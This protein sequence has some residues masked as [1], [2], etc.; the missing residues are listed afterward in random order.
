MEIVLVTQARFGS[1]RFRGKILEKINKKTILQIH[2]ENLKKSKLVTQ[3][4]V[5]TTN[6]IESQLICNIAES[7]D[8]KYYKTSFF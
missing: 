6:E 3:Y 1:S 8:F 4:I 7:N 2:L 5:A